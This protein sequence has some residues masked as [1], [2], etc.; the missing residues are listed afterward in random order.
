M[1]VSKLVVY[2]VFLCGALNTY[3]FVIPGIQEITNFNMLLESMVA[4]AVLIWIA[5]VLYWQGWKKSASENLVAF[6]GVICLLIVAPITYSTFDPGSG[7]AGRNAGLVL[8][9][10][11]LAYWVLGVV[12]FLWQRISASRPNA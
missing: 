9:V 11:S 8:V 10:A 2:S 3:V 4:L 12:A 6:P 5:I 1:L 7:N